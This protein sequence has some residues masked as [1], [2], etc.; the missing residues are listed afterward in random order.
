VTTLPSFDQSGSEGL[1]KRLLGVVQS[2][3]G[4][5]TAEC[6]TFRTYMGHSPCSDGNSFYRNRGEET[7]FIAHSRRLSRA[8]GDPAVRISQVSA[9]GAVFG[10][11]LDP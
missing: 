6:R 5:R 11:W 1:R 10:E 4:E 8:V 3:V 2:G 9:A 7:M